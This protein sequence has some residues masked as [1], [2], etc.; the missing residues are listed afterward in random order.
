[1]EIVKV[2]QSESPCENEM[3]MQ[4]KHWDEPG[5][6][7]HS[8]LLSSINIYREAVTYVNLMDEKGNRTVL[9]FWR[10]ISWVGKGGE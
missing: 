1:M 3:Q 6:W 10:V 9:A 4:V 2:H 8:M 5:S 7:E